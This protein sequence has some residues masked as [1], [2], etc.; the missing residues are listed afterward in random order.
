MTEPPPRS[1]AV[2]FGNTFPKQSPIV[3]KAKQQFTA[4]D[5]QVSH[6]PLGRGVAFPALV[7]DGRI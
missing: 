6:Q 2:C 7:E 5:G 4:I 3:V 1:T